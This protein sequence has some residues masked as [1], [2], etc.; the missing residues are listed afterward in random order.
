MEEEDAT[1]HTRTTG[2]RNPELHV[3]MS[4][5]LRIFSVRPR[6]ISVLSELGPRSPPVFRDALQDDFDECSFRDKNMLWRQGKQH[7]RK[8]TSHVL[9]FPYLGRQTQWPIARSRNTTSWEISP[10]GCKVQKPKERFS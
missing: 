8:E 4:Y 2:L 3:H 6:Y 10:P 5:I 1:S 9:H 7:A